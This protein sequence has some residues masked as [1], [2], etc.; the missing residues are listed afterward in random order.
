MKKS[1]LAIILISALFLFTCKK[2]EDDPTFSA[3]S[4]KARVEGNWKLE[5]ASLTLGVKDSTGAYSSYVYTFD[6]SAYS[7][8]NTG[9]G[10]RFEG[11]ADLSVSFTKKGGFTMTQNLGNL[12]LDAS[13]TWDFQGSVGKQKNKERM[14]M[15]L[16][17]IK[18][19]S[20]EFDFFNKA[21]YDFTYSIKE[22]RDKKMVLSCD[23]EMIL[24]DTQA[25][26]YV[27]AEY[28][29]VQ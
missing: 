2:G 21:N 7:V 11:S 13:G 19:N 12:K 1:K 29:F 3:K 27:S 9:K 4:R 6:Q 23:E 15:R 5:K 18:G 16:S 14:L 28:T 20:N 25:G 22:L 10:S 8:A 26:L 24:L 17:S